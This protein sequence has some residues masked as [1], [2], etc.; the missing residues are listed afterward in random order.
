MK[1]RAKRFFIFFGVILGVFIIGFYLFTTIYYT[2]GFS[3]NTRINGLYCTGKSVFEVNELLSSKGKREY[4]NISSDYSPEESVDMSL[5]E[6]SIDYSEGLNSLFSKQKPFLWPIANYKSI[7]L[8]P[9]VTFNEEKLKEELLK[10]RVFEDFKSENES[11]VEIRYSSD[12]GYYLYENLIPVLDKEKALDIVINALKNNEDAFIPKEYFLEPLETEDFKHERLVYKEIEAF[13]E[14]KLT[15]DMGAEQIVIDKPILSRFLVRD[16]ANN[17]FCK[18]EDGSLMVDENVVI[19]YID[20]VCNQYDTYCKPRTIKT[21]LGEEKTINLSCYGTQLDKMAEEEYFL[22]AIKTGVTEVHTPK[23]LHEGYVRG[24]DDIG[25]TLIEVDMTNQIMY[26]LENG[27]VIYTF[28]VVTGKPTKDFT[29]PEM[30]AFVNKKTKG[31]YLRGVDYCS[32][33][34]YWMPIYKSIGLH[35]ASWQKNFGGDWY[36]KHGSR[37]CINMRL[38]DAE[39]LYNTIEVGIPVIVYK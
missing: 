36:L 30:I 18:N 1:S 9:K 4:F 19:E 21:H 7:S 22:N 38:E 17:D 10:L 3:F 20:S 35:D 2:N 14:P 39:T 8:N 27:D 12:L 11:I 5:I 6:Y 32:W 26:Y 28:D 37:G 31:R 33:V 15:F 24:L 13:L 25:N 23:Y 34:D 29:T 16:F